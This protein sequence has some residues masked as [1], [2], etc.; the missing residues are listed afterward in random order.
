M[1]NEQKQQLITDLI[2]VTCQCMLDNEPETTHVDN[3]YV[4]GFIENSSEDLFEDMCEFADLEYDEDTIQDTLIEI[5][6]QAEPFN[7]AVADMDSSSL[8]GDDSTIN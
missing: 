2:E 1:N 6:S 4:I 8:G 7:V 5:I 3:D